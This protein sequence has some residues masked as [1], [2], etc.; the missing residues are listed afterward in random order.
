MKRLGVKIENLQHGNDDL[1]RS[2]SL[3]TE[4][5]RSKDL[6]SQDL[7]LKLDQSKDTENQLL[8]KMSALREN[9]EQQI[10]KSQQA[11]AAAD[12][13]HTELLNLNNTNSALETQAIQLKQ[14]ATTM[15]QQV[16]FCTLNRISWSSDV[17]HF[18]DQLPCSRLIHCS[19]CDVCLNGL[20]LS[21]RRWL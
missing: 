9:L 3:A 21:Q 18:S 10:A 11:E 19:C 20:C 16:P 1:S 5:S 6:E 12:E 4:E 14:E 7:K 15:G 8:S 2:L 13:Q 17:S